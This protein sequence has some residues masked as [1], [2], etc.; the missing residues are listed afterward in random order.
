[1][2][3]LAIGLAA[4]IGTWVYQG[5]LRGRLIDV[6]KAERK[7]LRFQ[8]DINGADWPEWTLL[9]GVGEA[10]ARRI[11]MEREASGPYPRHEALLRVRGIGPRILERMRPYLL[12]VEAQAAA[13][14]DY[15]EGT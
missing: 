4:M 6:D 11:V 14:R 1:V 2:G 9:P 12:P 3:L 5:G 15:S 8:L 13:D 10:L 7:E